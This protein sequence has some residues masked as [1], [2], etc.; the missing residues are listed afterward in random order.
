MTWIFDK[1]DVNEWL[2]D[3]PLH[4]YYFYINK[5]QDGH[6]CRKN[7]SKNAHMPVCETTE[8]FERKHGLT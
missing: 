2:F 8:R 5:I 1:I 3:G 7:T 4:V 6:H